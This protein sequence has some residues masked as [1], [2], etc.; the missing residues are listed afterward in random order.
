MSIN[1]VSLLELIEFIPMN[2]N[3]TILMNNV[4][5]SILNIIFDKTK[6]SWA[7]GSYWLGGQIQMNPSELISLEKISEAREIGVKRFNEMGGPAN[8]AEM[9][10]I[11]TSRHEL[12]LLENVVENYINIMKDR[13]KNELLNKTC[14][15]TANNIINFL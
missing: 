4:D 7:N 8:W 11:N 13:I 12:N 1:E 3:E 2:D 9:N 10:S 15:D 5:W 14:N 6:T